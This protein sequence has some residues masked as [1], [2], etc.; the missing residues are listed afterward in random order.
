MDEI[1]FS[2]VPMSNFLLALAVG[3]GVYVYQDLKDKKYLNSKIDDA[4][5]RIDLLFD[6]IQ[7]R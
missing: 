2:I 4:N 1:V 5:R 7:R 6:E 3:F